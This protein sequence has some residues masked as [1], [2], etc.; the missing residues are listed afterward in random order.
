MQRLSAIKIKQPEAEKRSGCLNF[1]MH[2]V[3]IEYF[4]PNPLY[5]CHLPYLPHEMLF[6]FSIS[7]GPAP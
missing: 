3:I 6:G 1:I 7:S 2:R 5:L 4:F